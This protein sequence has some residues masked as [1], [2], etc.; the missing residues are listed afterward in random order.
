IR[1]AP[2]EALYGR[3]SRS[4]VLWAEIE[5]SRLIGPELVQETTDKGGTDNAKILRKRT[6]TD[7]GKD[8]EYK[9]RENAIKG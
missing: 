5:E 9:S 3:R 7:T 6:N 2:F 8:R 1:C 4:P